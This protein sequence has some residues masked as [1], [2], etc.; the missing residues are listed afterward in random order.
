MEQFPSPN[1]VVLLTD[2]ERFAEEPV[3]D[4]EDDE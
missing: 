3:D 2:G 1:N 4:E